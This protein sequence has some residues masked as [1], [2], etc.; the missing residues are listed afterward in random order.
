MRS[1][2][3]PGA[4]S[5]HS[6]TSISFQKVKIKEKKGIEEKKIVFQ[7]DERL[8]DRPH[9][10]SV[11]CTYIGS[12][13]KD[14]RIDHQTDAASLRWVTLYHENWM[15]IGVVQIA[16]VVYPLLSFFEGRNGTERDWTYLVETL[17]WI[18]LAAAL[19]VR[20][21]FTGPA[22]LRRSVFFVLHFLA[23]M[24][25]LIDL[26]YSCFFSHDHYYRYARLLRPVLQLE[27]APAVRRRLVDL[28]KMTSRIKAVMLLLFFHI[29]FFAVLAV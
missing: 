26:C 25:I 2:S 28:L 18:M 7:M 15:F 27:Y 19:T 5:N 22:R 8:I 1:E 20:I 10:L 16:L 17:C 11:A 21:H 14:R 24:I 12:A 3:E 29:I 9:S 6:G 23:L 4:S 13:M